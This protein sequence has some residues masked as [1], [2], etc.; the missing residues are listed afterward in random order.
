MPKLARGLTWTASKVQ[1]LGKLI[2]MAGALVMAAWDIKQGVDQVKARQHGI[3]AAYF[4]SAAL[5]MGA[6]AAL[7]FSWTGV[8]LLLVLAVMA[9]AVLIEYI[10]D[11]KVQSWLERCVWGKGPAP[12][13]GNEQEEMTQLRVAFS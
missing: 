5:G 8:G 7:F 11:N 10:K 6:A 12:R 1:L 4:A 2:G 9:V 3:A 13:Y